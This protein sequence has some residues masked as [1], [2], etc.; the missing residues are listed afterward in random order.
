VNFL[1]EAGRALL[2]NYRPVLIYMALAA[3]LKTGEALLQEFV[4][5]P[6]A[7]DTPDSL[8]GLELI[9]SRILL[10][11][12]FAMADSV[13]F[14]RIGREI[15][16][17][18]W[19]IATDREAIARFYK[20]WLLLGLANLMYLQLMERIFGIGGENSASFLLFLS[21]LVW[22]V[23]LLAF[24]TAV[25]FYGRTAREE[26]TEALNVMSRHASSV[27]GMCVLGAFAG[28]MMHQTY[29]ALISGEPTLGLKL[30]GNA[31]LATVDGFISCL[32]FAFMWLVCRYD[33]DHF[34]T[35]RED[36]DL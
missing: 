24:G 22:V 25:M 30:A 3:V 16:K 28:F 13:L 18:Y 7:G 17:P 27:M 20:L 11:A 1:R 4:L 33:R 5:A 32:L 14:A 36:F 31:I 10:V 26:M 15:D 6:V 2:E 35:D 12:I 23:I 8:L 19:R 9:G 34:E 29:W 21:Y